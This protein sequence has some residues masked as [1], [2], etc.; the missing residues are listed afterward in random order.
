[1]KT[2]KRPLKIGLTGSPGAGKSLVL[3]FLAQ[4]GVPTLQTDH[5][6]HGLLRDKAFSGKLARL[7]GRGILD[8]RGL[9]DR[10]KLGVLVFKDPQKRDLLNRSIH[11]RIRGL[12]KDWV[13]G[14]V[15]TPQGLVVV[16]VPLLFERGFYKFF[17]GILSVSAP[18]VLRRKRLSQRGWDVAQI[19]KRERAQWSQVRKDRMAD[20]VLMNDRGPAETKKKV[21][22]W[23]SSVKLG[24]LSPKKKVF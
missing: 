5:L 6:G 3:R 1:M 4:K 8:P 13:R 19:R 23:L 9:V 17:D 14:K 24:L 16:E 22:L 11:P 18:R 20:W 15:G 2:Q 10:Q 7:L 21:A 12:V